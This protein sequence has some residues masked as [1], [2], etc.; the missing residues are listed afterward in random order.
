[1]VA[2]L[3]PSGDAMPEN[4]LSVSGP[5]LL[6]RPSGCNHLHPALHRVQEAMAAD[7]A[8]DWTVQRM[9]DLAFTSA[10]HLRQI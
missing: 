4:V 2:G 7:P 6:A 9:A 10:R 1:M 8:G 3:Q 5:V